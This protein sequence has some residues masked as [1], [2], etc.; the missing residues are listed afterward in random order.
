[1]DSPRPNI[2]VFLLDAARARNFSCYGYERE[3]TPF[4]DRLAASGTR[5]EFAFANSIY[6]LPSYASLFTG[7]Y[8]TEHGALDWNDSI[9]ENTLVRNLNNA[10]YDTVAVSTHLVSD[11]FGFGGAFDRTESLFLE[12]KD[13]IFE[14]DPVADRMREHSGR[15]GW[16]SDREKYLFFLKQ[17]LRSPSL[18]SVINGGYKFYRKIKKSRGWWDDDGA[19]LAIET[20]KKEVREAQ[21]PFFLFTNFIETHD[22]YRPPREYLR[23]FLPDDA[24]LSEI[25][26]AL[27]YVSARAT[28]GVDEISERQRRLLIDLYDA[29]IR[30]IDEK[31]REFVEFLED[32]GLRDDTVLVVLSD[33]GDAFGDHGLWGH[34]GRIYNELCHVP[35]IIDYPWR[36]NETVSETTELRQ[37][38]EHLSSL[39]NGGRD[40][41]SAP[42]EALIEYYGWDTQ[43]SFAPWEEYD[44]ISLDDWGRYQVAFVDDRLKLIW[45]ASGRQE[46]YDLN[47]DYEETTDLSVNRGEDV[48]ALAAKIVERVGNPEDNDT[49]YRQEQRGIDIEREQDVTEHLRDLG[50]VE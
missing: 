48:D 15:E 7:E 22:P 17:F 30:Y 38:S 2:A 13:V 46:L 36:G 34:Q 10:G 11:E 31:I 21:T 3:T 43:L 29:E 20:A 40:R 18:K 41:M 9:T 32:E 42:G 27:E 12:S 35:L 25:K 39:A 45:D 14:D 33:H 23:E 16:E 49:R 47:I 4:V 5:Y 19:G 37:L 6:S 1:M 50:Y 8:P 44:G 28:A 24:T 26:E